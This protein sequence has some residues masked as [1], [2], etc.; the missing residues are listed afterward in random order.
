VQVPFT[1]DHYRDGVQTSRV[2]YESIEFNPAIPDA[3]FAKPTNPKA[4][5]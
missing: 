3:L 1:I 5:K 4:I 2:N